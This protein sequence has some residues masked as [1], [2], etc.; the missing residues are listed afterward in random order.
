MC[1][2][3]QWVLSVKNLVPLRMFFISDYQYLRSEAR[4]VAAHSIMGPAPSSLCVFPWI[5]SLVPFQLSCQSEVVFCILKN[6][7]QGSSISY[8]NVIYF[9]FINQAAMA[10]AVQWN[11]TY[12]YT[13]KPPQL[14][15]QERKKKKNKTILLLVLQ[16]PKFGKHPKKYF[17]RRYYFQR[18]NSTHMGC[19][20]FV[21]SMEPVTAW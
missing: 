8:G 17:K 9:S 4:S 18:L 19:K 20:R 21:D 7:V 13:F 14:L 10:W 15:S 16:L 5:C 11:S 3:N 6:F 1:V 12:E 2:Q